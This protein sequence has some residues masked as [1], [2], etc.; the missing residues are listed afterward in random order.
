MG[1]ND[2]SIAIDTIYL[3][4]TCGSHVGAIWFLWLNECCKKKRR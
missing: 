4:N 3:Q 1:H 2:G